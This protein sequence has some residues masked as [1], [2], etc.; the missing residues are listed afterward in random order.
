MVAKGGISLFRKEGRGEISEEYVWSIMDF[1]V[2]MDNRF[3]FLK[4]FPMTRERRA[5]V[6]EREDGKMGGRII[7]LAEKLEKR[8]KRI[9][10]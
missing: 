5:H 7:E 4:K 1:L 8:G 10:I 2:S 9:L 6:W 3:G